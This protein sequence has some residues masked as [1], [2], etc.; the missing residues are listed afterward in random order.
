MGPLRVWLCAPHL[1]GAETQPHPKLPTSDRT[2]SLVTD[3]IPPSGA[4]LGFGSGMNNALIRSMIDDGV[5]MN[6]VLAIERWIGRFNRLSYEERLK[7]TQR[8]PLL[9]S[10][11]EEPSPDVIEA[12]IGKS[13]LSHHFAYLNEYFAKGRKLTDKGNLTLADARHLVEALRTDDQLEYT[14]DRLYKVRSSTE[15]PRLTGIVELATVT[16]ADARHLVEALRTDDQLEYTIDRL[17][18]VRSST[19]L[20]RLTGIVELATAC[21]VLRLQH[22]KL[23]GTKVWAQSFQHDAVA[24]AERWIAS[25]RDIG[26]ATVVNLWGYRRD[27]VLEYVDAVPDHIFAMLYAGGVVG[28]SSVLDAV[29]SNYFNYLEKAGLTP[30]SIANKSL[31]WRLDDFMW[32]AW[33]CGLIECNGVEIDPERARGWSFAS[34]KLTELGY[35]SVGKMLASNP[36]YEFS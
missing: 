33:L 18:K 5:D 12:A 15:L 35:M 26:F 25:A 11:H 17:Y 34:A 28:R 7:R 23:I 22:G 6:D 13:P 14:I 30:D 21:K 9:L 32:T 31:G 2:V 4:E 16:L 8:R 24:A 20:P 1:R 36:M 10:K 3:G 29:S 27:D 19:E